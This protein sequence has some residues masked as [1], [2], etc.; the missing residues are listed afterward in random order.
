MKIYE[1][2]GFRGLQ[3]TLLVPPNI[4]TVLVVIYCV[5]SVGPLMYYFF[6]VGIS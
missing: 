4:G 2:T 3:I 6:S 1:P 5:F